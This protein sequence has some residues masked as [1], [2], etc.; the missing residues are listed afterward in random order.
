VLYPNPAKTTVHIENTYGATNYIITDVLGKPLLN[1]KDLVNYQVNFLNTLFCFDRR[2]SQK[3]DLFQIS[4]L[5]PLFYRD[6]KLI[7]Y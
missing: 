1:K 6:Q 2:H 5:M 7:H 3:I 4:F